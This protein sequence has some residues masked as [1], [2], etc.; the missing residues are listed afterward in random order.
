MKISSY[1]SG[2]DAEEICTKFL[3]EKKF[4]ITATRYKTKDG[5]V[6][7]I[8]QN[9]TTLIFVEVKKRKNFG[10]DDPISTKQKK[11]IANAALQY[12]SENPEISNLDM[13]FDSIFVDSQNQLTHIEDAWRL[14][15]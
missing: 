3:S 4:A 15:I 5:E 13:R 7:I 6:D 11:R 1:K 12:I 2:V 8:A 9:K 10:F 14:N